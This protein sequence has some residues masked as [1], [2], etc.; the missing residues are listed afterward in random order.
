[1]NSN[2]IEVQNFIEQNFDLE[3]WEL[4]EFPFYP[5][6]VLL[7]DKTGESIVIYYDILKNKV[8]WEVE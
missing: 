2:R 4:L 6:G 8:K 5:G 1:M 7:K 3:K